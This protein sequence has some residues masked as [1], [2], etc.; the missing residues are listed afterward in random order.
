MTKE[1]DR[2]R[3]GKDKKNLVEWVGGKSR[4]I[5]PVPGFPPSLTCAFL[6]LQTPVRS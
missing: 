3:D 6:E 5:E 1:T 2:T 4:F